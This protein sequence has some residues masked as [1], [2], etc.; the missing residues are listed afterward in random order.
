MQRWGVKV[1]GGGGF[2][3]Q[4]L[5]RLV[6]METANTVHWMAQRLLATKQPDVDDYTRWMYRR[7]KKMGLLKELKE[8][9]D[10]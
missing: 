9:K 10:A 8:L 4:D 7:I 3:D 5:R 6:Q 1:P 2:L